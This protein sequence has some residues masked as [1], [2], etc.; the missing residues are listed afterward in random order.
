[1][2]GF[3]QALPVT[4]RFEG[5]FANHPADP[6][7]ATMKGVTQGTYDAFRHELGQPSAPVREI[8]DAE[9]ELIYHTR[10]WTPAKCDALPWPASLCHFDASVNHGLTGAAK[11]LQ[12]AA[13]VPDD[14]KI[15][16]NTLAAIGAMPVPLLVA[17]ML[18]ERLDYYE[19]ICL[20][21]PA[22][23]VF[24]LAWLSRVNALRDRC[25][26]DMPEVA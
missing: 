26:Q 8:T 9:V 21:R 25:R 7:G 3:Y 20:G 11:L 18:F 13:G 23:R 14:G 5:G 24:L 2:S 6:G 4:L 15:G 10:Y 1:M 19:R 16:P 12:R 17:R 22:S